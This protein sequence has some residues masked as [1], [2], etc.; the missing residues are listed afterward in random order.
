MAIAAIA[1]VALAM[2]GAPAAAAAIAPSGGTTAA[3]RDASV[4]RAAPVD[5]AAGASQN[6]DV[7][8]NRTVECWGDNTYGDLGDGTTVSSTR[9]VLVKG[10]ADVTQVTL[11]FGHTCALL[12]SG[13]VECWGWNANGQLG[14]GTERSTD[15]PVP[16]K[17]LPPVKQIAVG[18]ETSCALLFSG[19]VRCW[20]WNG[21]GQLGDGTTGTTQTPV[22]VVGLSGA[23]QIAVGYE[24]SCAVVAGGAVRCW[25]LNDQGQ[26]GDGG[27]TQSTRP[28]AVRGLAG[29]RQISLGYKHTCAVLDSGIVK[30]WGL[31]RFGQLGDGSTVSSPTP[32]TV[33]DLNDAIEVGSAEGDS[34]ALLRTHRIKCWGW[35]GYGQLGTSTRVSSSVPVTT[36]NLANV[37][38][39]AVGDDHTCALLG[40]EAYTCW[41]SNVFGQLG[42]STT[43]STNVPPYLPSA[44]EAVRARSLEGAALVSWRPPHLSG[45]TRTLSYTVS[46]AA[47]QQ[48]CA[49]RTYSCRV[50]GL[51]NGATYRFWVTAA[52]VVGSSRPS[53]SPPVVPAT[54]PDPPITVT[55]QREDEGALVSWLAPTSDGGRAIVAYTATASPGGHSCR[56]GGLVCSV[57]GLT[58]GV[59]YTFTVTAMN[60]VGTG[61]VSAPSAAVTPA[62]V[63]GRPTGVTAK[64]GNTSASVT[65]TAPSANGSAITAYHVAAADETTAGNGGETCA[66]SGTVGCT[67]SGLTNGD[68]YTFTVSA[69]NA[70]GAGP[71]SAASPAV[72]PATIPGAPTAV[73]ASP[74]DT[75]AAVTWTAPTSD[76]GS[77]ITGYEVTSTDLTTPLNGGETCS[78]LGSIGCTVTELTNGDTYTFSVTATNVAGTSLPSSPSAEVTPSSVPGPP[79]GV[80]AVAGDTTA[81]VTWTAPTSDG[82][83]PITSY[84]VTATDVTTPADGGQTCSGT[85][86][87]TGCVA[88]SLTNGDAYTFTVIAS[89]AAGPGTASS[90]SAPVTPAALPGRPTGA[91]ATPGDASAAV[92]WTAPTS[93]GGSAISGYKVTAADHTHTGNGGETCSTSGTIGC[94]VTTLT[95]GDSYTFTVTATNGAGTGPASVASSAVTPY[96]VPD[97]PTGVTATP[98]AESASVTW[99]PGFDEGSA[100]SAYD[101]TAT[102]GTTPLNGGQTCATSG[103]V[104]CTVTGL[105]NGDSYTFTVTATNGAGTG[106]ASVASSAVTPYT[107]PDPPTGVTA[108]P[109]A[110]S[111]SVTWTPGFDEGSAIS[112]YDVTATDGTTPLNG[113]QTCA[114]SGTV[115]CT[116]TGLTNGDSYTF[117]VTATNG[118]G[119]GPASVASSA[120][121]P[122]TVPDPPTGV[123]ATPGAESA[124]VTWTPGFDEGSAISAYDVTATDGTTPLNG[125][126]TCATSGTVGCTVTGLT[127]GDS[128]TFTVTATNGA[129]TGLA[130]APSTAVVP[131]PGLIT[132]PVRAVASIDGFNSL[133][134]G[135]APAAARR[136]SSLVGTR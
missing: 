107:V 96:T 12:G 8:S 29:V 39:V 129:G 36:V 10:L 45:G 7:L 88:S 84:K 128:Y 52:N 77:P 105:T 127:D 75:S 48:L 115:G 5:I 119:T 69:T 132:L 97:P 87:A 123:T 114:T 91:T 136:L 2:A 112:A 66:T 20:G 71:T 14:D 57:A 1:I 72:T 118:A 74:G 32:V 90:P 54:V 61:A 28:V 73:T 65:W 31:N 124:S 4:P 93:D 63:P 117:T 134:L 80:T 135:A 79:T 16:V 60:S 82:G 24:H 108:T 41:G 94:T 53:A 33:R 30:C 44:P 46:S 113:G 21:N 37:D 11:S 116:V 103:T 49:L 59:P 70:E 6:C 102:D 18:F 13:A 50:T 125:G 131:M 15:R 22:S 58:N 40:A 43:K 130:S 89:N 55:A 98:G 78:T 110:E 76:G 42:T 34:C 3:H 56:T 126:Q 95:N 27:T 26:L 17:G 83:S 47:G 111:A 35:N 121:T 120:V 106:P 81:T 133:Y 101:V 100:I 86:P 99:T 51:T 104:G 122:Y 62:A 23:H 68:A 85:N 67:V 25:G 19:S 92:T 64:A 9:P 38:Q 109:G